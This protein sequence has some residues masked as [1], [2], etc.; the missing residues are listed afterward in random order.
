M[1]QISTFEC[2]QWI[3]PS[4]LP[5]WL[6][7]AKVPVYWVARKAFDLPGEV[8]G[9]TMRLAADRHY[10]LFVN[11]AAVKRRRG[12][13]S[14]DQYLFSETCADAA[15]WFRPGPNVIEVVLRSDPFQ[16]KNYRP[17][18]PGLVLEA[19]ATC[20]QQTLS[21]ATDA[22][23]E[24][25][26]VDGWRE[27]IGVGGNGTITFEKVQLCP[28]DK[29]YLS[30]FSRDLRFGPARSLAATLTE[31][32]TIY[33]WPD[34][35]KRIDTYTPIR[36]VDSGRCYLNDSALAFD[37]KKIADL[38]G[39]N[40]PIVLKKTF[41]CGMETWVDISTSYRI[42]HRIALNGD[43]V[44]ENQVVTKPE[45]MALP[46]PMVPAGRMR[47]A[48]GIHRLEIAVHPQLDIYLEPEWRPFRV[49]FRGASTLMRTEGW[50][51][52]NRAGRRSSESSGEG[53]EVE[54]E[55]RPLP[56]A[57]QVSSQVR[58]ERLEGAERPEV[59]DD[60]VTAPAAGWWGMPFAVLDF[61][62]A[63]AGTLRLRVEASS[64]GRILLAYGFDYRDGSLNCSKMGLNAVDILEVP[65]GPSEYRA[66]EARTFRCLELIFDGF[67]GPVTLSGIALE[68]KVYLDAPG[69]A[70][71]TDDGRVNQTWNVARRTAV[72]NCCEIYTD[73]PEREHAQWMD[74]TV[75]NVAGGYY[76]FRDY[77]QAARAFF[78][79]TL[80]Q[81]PDGQ[82]AGYAPGRWFPR[83]PLQCHTALFVVGAWRHF[84]HT[85][86]EA[87]GHH[88]LD[89]VGQV[90]GHWER[91]RTRDGLVAN[92]DTLFVDWG[93]HLYSYGSRS[94]GKPNGV[95]T[96]MN[97]YY[98]GALTK[99]SEMAAFLGRECEA[100]EYR[101]I[102]ADLRKSINAH[103]FDEREGLY[104]DGLDNPLAKRLYSQT[105]NALLV[106][107]GVAPASK[108]REIMTNAFAERKDIRI[109]P[110]SAHFSRQAASALFEAG[111]DDLALAW[112]KRG[113]GGMLDAGAT[114]FWEVWE[115]DASQCQ[116]TSSSPVYLFARYLAGL[117][118]L[119]PGYRKIGI[120]P[121][122][123]GLKHLTAT[124]TTPLGLVKIAW[125]RTAQGL[126]YT[127]TLPAKLRDAPVI[128]ADR[129]GSVQLSVV[130]A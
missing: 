111:C 9:A 12:F 102:A 3:A 39:S 85:G 125:G 115:D 17:F 61:G 13:F 83:T 105:A 121:H 18:H 42:A 40:D 112:L 95:L 64:A 127:L 66:F 97:G 58:M 104:R 48:A 11:G 30:G 35:P 49:G 43:T 77:S 98:H 103:L 117:Y 56:L 113:F 7:T 74:C 51:V 116:G 109:L 90:I 22:T 57:E 92:V 106:K 15:A 20:G 53:I 81:Q 110:A 37:L 36:A 21:V 25:A 45:C 27:V 82:L 2:G 47:T 86:D 59:R 14:G 88:L 28:R 123:S 84:L 76:A 55:V 71:E 38:R 54:P 60:S 89:T 72:L 65:A 50:T 94:R 62:D 33:E 124:L 67:E 93:S 23:W 79:F 129:A 19:D 4:L 75:A 70:F 1:L 120:D 29:A 32:L 63:I 80:T 96:T 114:T 87:F 101:S 26:V 100:K 99:A 69:V 130:S 128:V 24:V 8:T 118:P 31:K 52:D 107:F 119:E 6:E 73:N 108:R 16:N 126:D 10:D 78:E 5:D 46:N 68:E 34:R 41:D 91:H 122:P 44:Y